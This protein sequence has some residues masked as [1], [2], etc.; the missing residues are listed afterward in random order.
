M[1]IFRK[2]E[3][4]QRVMEYTEALASDLR[5][6]SYHGRPVEVEVDG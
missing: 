1:P 5:R 6:V 3:D 4:R 2:A